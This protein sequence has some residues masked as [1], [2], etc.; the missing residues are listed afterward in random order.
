MKY[1][2][3][4]GISEDMKVFLIMDNLL[5]NVFP[6]IIKAEIRKNNIKKKVKVDIDL[7]IDVT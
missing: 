3:F 5:E 6:K 7:S 4:N 2:K 1:D